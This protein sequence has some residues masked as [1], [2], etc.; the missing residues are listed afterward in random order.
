MKGLLFFLSFLLSSNVY[1]DKTTKLH[2]AVKAEKTTRKPTQDI[3]YSV[4]SDQY[5][6]EQLG[7]IESE[8]SA[9]LNPAQ[10]ERILATA[11]LLR[12]TNTWDHLEKDILILRA[13]KNSLE[14]L[15]RKYPKIPAVQLQQLRILLRAG[16]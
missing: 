1:A 8:E 5:P 13:S 3:N 14:D 16:K 6:K 7:N 11:N 10:R 15:Q 12:H 4:F 9:V 2:P